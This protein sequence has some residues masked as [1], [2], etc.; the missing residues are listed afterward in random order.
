[1]STPSHS[2]I[3]LRSALAG[4]SFVALLGC[5][6]LSGASPAP[7]IWSGSRGSEEYA[8]IDLPDLGPAAPA[9]P[10]FSTDGRSL[11]LGDLESPRLAV[12][13]LTS[14]QVR[15]IPIPFLASVL[16]L[17]TDGDLL[18]AVGRNGTG[19]S[20]IARVDTETW[21]VTSTDLADVKEASD[22]AIA[23][24]ASRLFVGDS[25]CNCLFDLD[26]TS[27]FGNG[28]GDGGDQGSGK[29]NLRRIYL[30]NGPAGE[31]EVLPADDRLLILHRE[32]LPGQ[33]AT[34]RSRAGAELSLIDST[35]GSL[36]DYLWSQQGF[37]TGSILSVP[38]GSEAARFVVA[39]EED[40]RRTLV[41]YQVEDDGR[42][43][44]SRARTLAS[45][46]PTRK[47]MDGK[48]RLAGSTDG[49]TLAVL[50]TDEREL[51]IVLLEP[52]AA[53]TPPA[54]IRQWTLRVPRWAHEVAVSP[55]GQHL[56][57]TGEGNIEL[58]R[59]SAR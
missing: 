50:N 25:E 55:D 54:L 28:A 11:I 43:L 38:A 59:R 49:S 27:L 5:A 22:L 24:R 12:F 47:P 42:D 30:E 4:V 35:R 32:S 46:P 9:S 34:Y 29:P 37:G 1:M 56:V 18:Y 20:G 7:G 33:T 13:D 2:P 36:V 53:G 10:V 16:E 6:T 45:W 8:R 52:G 15:T 21:Q 58:Y 51:E 39:V 44:T 40:P 41:A 14:S 48:L 23:R 3:P 57:V 17:S 19:G 31:I 26:L